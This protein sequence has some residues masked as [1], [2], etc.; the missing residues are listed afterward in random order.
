M[1][2]VIVPG[3]LEI[4]QYMK[5]RLLLLS[6]LLTISSFSQELLSPKPGI[7]IYG[8]PCLIQ[9]LVWSCT[10]RTCDSLIIMAGDSIEFCT[11]QEIHLNVDTAYWLQWNFY[12]AANLA[13]TI[14]HGY[15]NQVPICHYPR[16]DSAGTFI[17]EVFYNGWLSAYPTSDCYQQGPS[18]WFVKVVVLPN[19]NGVEESVKTEISFI[20]NPSSGKFTLLSDT[21][22]GQVTI[23]DVSGRILFHTNE[24]EIDMM[25]YGTGVYLASV[26]DEDMLRTFV[27]VVE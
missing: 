26:I 23:T 1:P 10:P 13:D 12:G 9:N 14:Y 7:S 18:H 5:L 3:T 24:K 6:L 25:M 21:P 20:P 4:T 8:S 19:P 17:V 27:L 11:Y 22:R 15:P 16:W 2:L